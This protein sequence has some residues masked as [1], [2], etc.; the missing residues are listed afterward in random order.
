MH[1]S[2]KSIFTENVVAFTQA[3]L[4]V[5]RLPV[6]TKPRYVMWYNY[7]KRRHYCETGDRHGIK[8]KIIRHRPL[9]PLPEF[10]MDIRIFIF[11]VSECNASAL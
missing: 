4:G 3:L 1:S 11:T 7:K 10:V 9:S 6:F 5:L 8:K 2:L